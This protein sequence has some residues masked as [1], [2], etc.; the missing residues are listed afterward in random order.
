MS[1]QTMHRRQLAGRRGAAGRRCASHRC[2]ARPAFRP[3][4]GFAM[5][6]IASRRGSGPLEIVKLDADHEVV[7]L[8][9]RPISASGG[10]AGLDGALAPEGATVE[11][12]EM[13]RHPIP[14]AERRAA[15]TLLATRAAP[16]ASSLATACAASS[17][18]TAA[19]T[20][21]AFARRAG[22]A[23]AGLVWPHPNL[24]GPLRHNADQ[25]GPAAQA[26]AGPRWRKG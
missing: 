22:I 6:L 24:S 10:A 1:K 25:V 18:G 15:G 3:W 8:P 23:A 9:S 16:T 4:P 11:V 26:A 17:A 5:G 21:L 14:G 13:T 19:G 20:A 2:C 12:A 7:D